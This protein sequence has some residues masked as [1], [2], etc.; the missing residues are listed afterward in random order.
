EREAE[1]TVVRQQPNPVEQLQDRST[2]EAAR[3]NV[4]AAASGAL[5]LRQARGTGHGL[6][7]VRVAERPDGIAIDRVDAGG[8]FERSQA[9]PATGRRFL[10]KRVLESRGD[11]DSWTAPVIV[12]ALL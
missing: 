3:G 11:D 2:A 8:R 1:R 9:E 5:R 4:D 10:G 7:E 6:A 12:L